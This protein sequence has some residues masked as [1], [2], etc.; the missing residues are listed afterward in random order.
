M[1]RISPNIR[2]GA[3]VSVLGPVVGEII[4]RP[5]LGELWKTKRLSA[6]VI[7]AAPSKNKNRWVISLDLQPEARIEVAAGHMKFEGFFT[8]NSDTN[9]CMNDESEEEGVGET[10]ISSDSDRD[11]DCGQNE[12]GEAVSLNDANSTLWA[13]KIITIDS[14]QV[15]Y[16]YSSTPVVHIGDITNVMP[17]QFFEHFM[18]VDFI[19]SVVIP[20]TNR[21]ARECERGWHDLTWMEF[22]KFIG[23]LT[24]M[25]Y[26]KCADICDYWSNKQDTKRILLTFGQYMPHQR[27]R[28]I[29]KYLKLTDDVSEDNDDPFYFARQFHDAFNEN[30]KMAV[31]PSTYLCI[32]ES[33]CQW[34]GKVDKGPFQQKIPRKP[35]LI[36]CEFKTIADAQVN[37]LL[38]LDP[39]EPPAYITKKKF[40]DQYPPTVAS[41]LRLTEPWFRSGRTIIGDSWF[42]SIDTCTTLYNH[43]LYSILQ[44]KKHR[45][46]PKY[47]PHDIIDALEDAYRSFV[48]RARSINNVDLTV[49]S[50]RDRKKIVLLASC[51]TTTLGSEV[52]RYIKDC[53]NVTFHRSVLFDEYCEY[54][55]AVDI[56]NNLRNNTLS[57]HDV[58]VSKCSVDRIFAFYLS[59]VEA[60]S[61][62]AYCRFVPEKQNIK[63]VDFRKQ[64]VR[65]NFDYYLGIPVAD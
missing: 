19:N 31:S 12:D 11:S 57:Y 32:D 44:I 47:I 41:V 9:Q 1:G 39:V 2:E 55:S 23:I 17:R 3:K 33:M 8:N 35:H 15:S 53:S 13:N 46:W 25:T 61:F 18:P 22:M 27:F 51:F 45:Y 29:I 38:R 42:G 65:L 5:L 26:I 60:N 30:L 36:G 34:M 10:D 49:C 7:Q 37:L 62:F 16:S 6:T 48:S 43:G 54:K 24:I 52:K 58:L 14:R 63:H 40:S 64:L 59:I 56:L 50:L 20:S 21:C 4:A 28:K